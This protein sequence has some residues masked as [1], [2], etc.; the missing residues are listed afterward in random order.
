[1][2]ILLRSLLV[3]LALMAGMAAIVRAQS[4]AQPAQNCQGAIAPPVNFGAFYSWELYK[5]QNSRQFDSSFQCNFF[6]LINLGT[7]SE[8]KVTAL[9]ANGDAMVASS[10]GAF[11][12]PYK[13]YSD[14]K[15]TINLPFG[16]QV[17]LP[18]GGLS[19]LGV[20][21]SV[22]GSVQLFLETQAKAVPIA[23]RYTDII[24]LRW[25]WGYC[26][27]GALGLCAPWSWHSGTATTTVN[28]AID[29]NKS[30][31]F[32][33]TAATLNFD[34]QPLVSMFK[35]STAK[36]DIYCTL[37]APYKLQIGDGDNPAN[38]MRR[39]KGPG[40]NYIEYQLYQQGTGTV[41]SQIAPLNGTGT[42]KDESITIEGRVNTQQADVPVGVYIDKPIVTIEY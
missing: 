26:S 24:T 9:S 10:G 23:G 32:T 1:M 22:G 27:L 37:N 34:P 20:G 41:L 42:G 8:L 25:E 36:L 40:N 19:F 35:P 7:N 11:R 38:G 21:G 15:Q 3:F 5:S 6:S 13:L 14:A 12:V 16:Q 39:M 33:T 30:C 29:V 4:P 17:N 18:Q 28:V 31:N 2:R